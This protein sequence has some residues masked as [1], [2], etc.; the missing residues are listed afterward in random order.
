MKLKVTWDGNDDGSHRLLLLNQPELKLWVLVKDE[1]DK[2]VAGPCSVTCRIDDT[3]FI[4][5]LRR[6][7]PRALR[8]RRLRPSLRK[9]LNRLVPSQPNPGTPEFVVRGQPGRFLPYW[10]KFHAS[11]GN[12]DE[13][14]SIFVAPRANRW[15]SL[16]FALMAA[17]IFSY[18]WWLWFSLRSESLP[19]QYLSIFGTASSV[20]APLLALGSPIISKTVRRYALLDA[21][22]SGAAAVLALVLTVALVRLRAP[23]YI[24]NDTPAAV[25]VAKDG[26]QIVIEPGAAAVLARDEVDPS[27]LN[28]L[29]D[30]V[31]GKREKL[32]PQHWYNAGEHCIL[33]ADSDGCVE[34]RQADFLTRL[35]RWLAPQGGIRL[36]CNPI[37]GL[38]PDAMQA[39]KKSGSCRHDPDV[40]I[41]RTLHEQ[42]IRAKLRPDKPIPAPCSEP[43]GSVTIH[44]FRVG[45]IKDD[46]PS[47]TMA[48]VPLAWPGDAGEG[49]PS[50]TF[51][52]TGKLAAVVLHPALDERGAPCAVPYPISCDGDPARQCPGLFA[53]HGALSATLAA[54][55]QALGTLEC[56]ASGT[57]LALRLRSRVQSLTVTSSKT[58][59]TLSQFRSDPEANGGWLAWCE[60]RLEKGSDPHGTVTEDLVAELTLPEDWQPVDGWE[61]HVPAISRIGALTII[62]RGKGMWG[63][64]VCP[65]Q[66]RERVLWLQEVKNTSSPEHVWS[67][68]AARRW[69]RYAGTDLF[70]HWFWRCGAD[71]NAET[72]AKLTARYDDG[73]TGSVVGDRFSRSPLAACVINPV[74]GLRV[75]GKRAEKGTSA[76]PLLDTFMVAECDSQRSVLAER[77]P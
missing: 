57:V 52:S 23:V 19:K 29:P 58:G 65:A 13:K 40:K 38:E 42:L 6:A 11:A 25:N 68:D 16:C 2:P 30:L 28:A 76:A 14:T 1:D 55:K 21:L 54:G 5:W 61:W 20:V 73:L 60:P 15:A 31:R 18:F 50:W 62:V 43:S 49:L 67:E 70:S 74:T 27:W 41:T 4:A 69:D 32:E 64:L 51:T 26:K 3:K 53:P 48:Q 35:Q 22:A 39:W 33:Q 72:S 9:R 36:G 24:E 46:R 71:R 77:G 59:K 17:L 8:P 45:A 56:S 34:L 10:L 75:H 47:E 66:G 44:P 12:A 7:T 37:K 63:K